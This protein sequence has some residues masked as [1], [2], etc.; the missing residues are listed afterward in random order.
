MQSKQEQ[1]P[2]LLALVTTQ[3]KGQGWVPENLQVSN[4]LLRWEC[5]PS[6]S[7]DQSHPGLNCRVL[8]LTQSLTTIGGEP[9]HHTKMLRTT[10][11]HLHTGNAAI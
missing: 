10:M 9:Y 6:H 2:R 3:I 4:L 11:R 7:T 5:N 1:R 8:A